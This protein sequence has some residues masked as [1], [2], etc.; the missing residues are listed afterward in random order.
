MLVC[1]CFAISHSQ[2]DAAIKQGATSEAEIGALLGVG[3]NCSNCLPTIRSRLRAAVG[4][5][6]MSPRV[7]CARLSRGADEPLYGTASTI[8]R[9]IL[10]EEPGTG[11]CDA[12]L[13]Q[14]VPV[15]V[16]V[17][18]KAVSKQLNARVLLIRR[19]GRYSPTG[20]RCYV[21]SSEPGASW[22]EYHT[23]DRSE[24]ILDIDWTPLREGRSV[25]G[26]PLP[27]ALYLVC[28][29]GRHDACCAEFGRPVASA[30]QENHAERVWESSHLGGDRFAA[31]MV[32]L[33]EGLYF[34]R[35]DPANASGIVTLYEQGRLDLAHYRGRS[36]YPVPVQVAEHHIRMAEG[37]DGLEDLD[38]VATRRD[39]AGRICVSFRNRSGRTLGAVLARRLVPVDDRPLT[40]SSAAVS[41]MARFELV[42]LTR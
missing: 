13:E 42:S 40:C 11:G 15:E 25:G 29:N 39:D 9:W 5:P 12:V 21:A 8:Q 16:A 34:G 31:N 28:T 7:S 2:V 35:V 1:L 24:D 38:F 10:L 26:R 27:H 41:A 33:P 19:H 32:L 3:T 14:R 4:K 37:L 20:R 30:L 17:R 22:A 18:L 6:A 23:L 36:C